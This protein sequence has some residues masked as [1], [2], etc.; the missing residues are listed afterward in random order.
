MSES[1]VT[2]I[3]LVII[4]ALV[5]CGIYLT[6]RKDKNEKPTNTGGGKGSVAMPV[7]EHTRPGKPGEQDHQMVE[8]LR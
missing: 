4:V 7:D 2:V 5:S 8:A 1:V 6:L 3:V